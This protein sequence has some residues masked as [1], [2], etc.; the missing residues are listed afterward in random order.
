MSLSARQTVKQHLLTHPHEFDFVQV[1]R[2]LQ[3]I[4]QQES[5]S[6]RLQSDPM[7]H[8]APTEVTRIEKEHDEVRVQLGL[9][10]LSGC[11]G[12]IPDYLYAEM[13][14]SLHQDDRALQ[15]FLDVFNQ[16]YYEL[17]AYVESAANLMLREERE[18]AS[19]YALSRLTQKQAL[20][21]MFSLPMQRGQKVD[22][23]VLRYGLAL[24]SRNRNLAQLKRLLCDY[25]DL[26]I[27][28]KVVPSAVY[29]IR[30]QDQTRIGGHS[31]QNHR[32]GRG[33][34]MGRQ[35]NQA[36]QTLEIWITPRNRNEFIGLERNRHFAR[37]L[38]SLV[39][40]YLRESLETRLYLYVKREYINAPVISA[41]AGG[42][43]LGEAS[44]LSPQRRAA[45]YRKIL[46]QSEN[47]YVTGKT[48]Q[49]G[50]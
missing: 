40:S 26:D 33:M 38:K 15:R 18:A 49:P 32:L 1:I 30:N 5:L 44:C 45:D 41:V 9:E 27:T 46:L 8:G 28:P 37:S 14:H 47:V 19:R 3:A 25:F 16:R 10:A 23:S 42:V 17:K 24:A 13:L 7:P 43:H 31:G 6:V 48:G 12:V 2:L 39:Q 21:C 4:S 34:V 36:Y 35:G 50:Q 22:Q 29:R 11:K 20:A